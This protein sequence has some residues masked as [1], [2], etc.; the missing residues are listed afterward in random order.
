MV[1]YQDE[2]ISPFQFK[3]YSCYIIF[4]QKYLSNLLW[5]A[6]LAEQGNNSIKKFAS[7]N[8][9]I[10]IIFFV[11]FFVINTAFGGFFHIIIIENIFPTRSAGLKI[12][13][14]G[15]LITGVMGFFK[16]MRI[17]ELHQLEGG[18]GLPASSPLKALITG[19]RSSFIAT[20]IGLLVGSYVQI[21]NYSI[22]IVKTL[23]WCVLAFG[24]AP[25]V[26]LIAYRIW[27]LSR[28]HGSQSIFNLQYYSLMC[29]SVH[30]SYK[31]IH[32]V[33]SDFMMLLVYL[34]V[35][36]GFSANF[37]FP[38]GFVVSYFILS[39]SIKY[40][41]IM[42]PTV[43]FLGSST[44]LTIETKRNLTSSLFP[45]RVISFLS[46]R[47]CQEFYQDLDRPGLFRS[48]WDN[49]RSASGQDWQRL[50]S[51]FMDL[52]KIIIVETRI[53]TEAVIQ[54]IEWLL[55]PDRKTKS[56]FIIGDDGSS[57]VLEAFSGI[58][59]GSL[60]C[61]TEKELI[62]WIKAVTKSSD[63]LPKP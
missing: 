11:P 24:V 16:L 7:R 17:W 5:G 6:I 48:N 23:N 53:P 32:L 51:S 28:L 43:L 59:K 25:L 45:L 52:A 41:L 46:N 14:L 31:H 22:N 13:I 26:F 21:S 20:I 60:K 38:W 37:P 63:T 29:E 57:P 44:N 19:F 61:I 40:N 47:D 12:A 34:L 55:E 1:N 50:V 3:T 36:F 56:C 2:P 39:K 35:G 15:S 18:R 10:D 58:Q 27:R 8:N 49:L 4:I 42:P 33:Y 54:E 9:F 30:L 62:P